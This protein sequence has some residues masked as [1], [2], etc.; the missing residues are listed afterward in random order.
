MTK[1]I[2]YTALLVVLILLMVEIITSVFYYHRYGKRTL[3]VVELY[4]A[5]KENLR[6]QREVEN[7]TK[8]NY[9]FQQLVRPD[10]S[11]QMNRQVMMKRWR[12]INL[13]ILHG[14]NS[15]TKISLVR[16]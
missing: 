11:E 1:K 13:F 9:Q 5:V 10:S 15:G 6:K 16:M 3:A 14:W 4:H 7:R 8:Q 12:L 2:F